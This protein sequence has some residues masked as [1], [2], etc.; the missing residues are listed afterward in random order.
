MILKGW[1]TGPEISYEHETKLFEP[2]LTIELIGRKID[3]GL[4]MSYGIIN[5]L[6]RHIRHRSTSADGVTCY[7]DLAAASEL[8]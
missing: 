4:S 8:R 7:F 6:G 3:L 1:D 5:S 2:L